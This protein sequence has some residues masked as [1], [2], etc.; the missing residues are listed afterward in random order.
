MFE[1]E[2]FRDNGGLVTTSEASFTFEAVDNPR[3]LDNKRNEGKS[4]DWTSQ[5]YELQGYTI[6]PYGKTDDLPREIRDV[7]LDNNI[8]PG[9]LRKKTQ[10]LWGKGGLLYTEEFD[11]KGK[12]YRKWVKDNEISDWLYSWDADTYITKACVDYDYAEGVGTMFKLNR[13]PRIGGRPF[14]AELEHRNLIEHRLAKESSDKGKK[15]T[16]CIYTPDNTDPHTLGNEH[17]VYPLFDFRDPF[18]YKNA[19]FYSSMY[20]FCSEHYAIPSIYGSLNWLRRSTAVPLILEAYIKN[21]INVKYHV[22]SPAKFWEKMEDEL[23]EKCRL[24]NKKYDASM[25]LTERTKYLRKVTKALSGADNT[26]KFWHTVKYV[27]V[28]GNNILEHGWEIKEIPGKIKD[29]I[30]GNLEIGRE[31]NRATAAGVGMHPAL[32]GAGE[33]GKSDSGSEQLYALK[34]YLITGIDIPEMIV[35]KALN[36]AIKANWPEKEVK[37][38]FYHIAPQRE[39]DTTSSDRVKNKV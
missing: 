11:E 27:E 33:S 24:D 8:A 19:Y 12:L 6:F 7:V 1:V 26:G 13:G 23:K 37:I 22:I 3:D 15:A 28:D 5:S 30:N 38:G 4:F 18:K 25:L 34:N 21:G 9:I 14:I 10:L 32:G 17:S 20:S 39:E 35:C 16:R 2:M 31:A 29:L 36:Y